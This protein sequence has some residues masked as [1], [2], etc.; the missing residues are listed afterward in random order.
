VFRY[1]EAAVLDEYETNGRDVSISTATQ[2]LPLPVTA[3][4]KK[5]ER[6]TIY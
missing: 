3:K 2:I 6:K 4:F 1:F 5:E